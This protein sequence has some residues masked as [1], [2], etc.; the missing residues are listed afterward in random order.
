[1]YKAFTIGLIQMRMEEDVNANLAKA[2]AMLEK[3]AKQGVQVACLP[4]LFRSPYFC[5][6]ENPAVFDLAESIPGKTTETIAAIARQHGMVIVA[7][8]FER[9]TAGIYHNTTAFFSAY[10]PHVRMYPNI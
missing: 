8:L 6:T 9:R 10:R 4:E 5:K 1:M 7:S 2:Q 3:A